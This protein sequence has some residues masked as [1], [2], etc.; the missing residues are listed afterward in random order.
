[1]ADPYDAVAAPEETGLWRINMETGARELLLSFAA[2]A[3]IPQEGGYSEGAKH[4]FNHLLYSPSG[5]R[6]IFLHRWRGKAE[7]TGFRTRLFTVG[8]DGRDLYALDPLG[9]TSHF[10]WKDD[11]HVFAWAWHWSHGER[12][13]LFKDRTR[14][15]EVVGKEQ[16]PVN[17]HNTYV[18]GTGFQWI[19]NDCYPDKHRLQHPYLFHEPSGR[20]VPLGHFHSPPAYTGEWRCDNHPRSSRD[21]GF[22]CI[23]SPHEGGR[24]MYLIDI[25]GIVGG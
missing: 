1:V 12:F 9:K 14:E 15:V 19:L 13:Y 25:R 17:G 3:A 6:F 5:E 18:P 16:M 11:A 2:V 4:W 20:R 22:V 24:Q 7:G 8:K 10:V 21:G 23:D